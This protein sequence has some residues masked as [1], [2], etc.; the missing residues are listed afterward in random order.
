[1]RAKI[2]WYFTVTF[3]DGTKNA[4]WDLTKAAAKALYDY[5]VK[6]MIVMNI[7]SVNW[8]SFVD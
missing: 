1:M 2:K 8:G 7:K 4:E 6:N 5:H 3:T